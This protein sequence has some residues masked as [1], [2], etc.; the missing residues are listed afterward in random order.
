MKAALL[1]FLMASSVL[2]QAQTRETRLAPSC[3]PDEVKFNVKREKNPHLMGQPDAAK[4]LVYFFDDSP[5]LGPFP[6]PKLTTRAGVDGKWVGATQGKS[7]FYFSV[8]P[9]EHHLCASWQTWLGPRVDVAHKTAA[10]HFTAE[11]G[12]M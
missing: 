12:G 6:N 10:A 9:G 1:I 4:A 8:D 11:A 3:P 2:A 7:Y 5:S